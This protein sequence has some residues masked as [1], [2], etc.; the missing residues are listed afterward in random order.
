[1]N[2]PHIRQQ[3]A[4][5]F[6]FVKQGKYGDAAQ[7]ASLPHIQSIK[8]PQVQHARG[9]T[10]L[11]IG[12]EQHALDAFLLFLTMAPE[13]HPIH[14]IVADLSAK[15]GKYELANT[16]FAKATNL[17]SHV[18]QYWFNW[19]LCWSLQNQHELAKAHFLKSLAIEP[20]FAKARF[21]HAKAC[22]ALKDYVGSE[23][24]LTTLFN[25]ETQQP[26]WKWHYVYGQVL[27]GLCRTEEASKQYQAALSLSVND[28]ESDVLYECLALLHVKLCDNEQALSWLTK[29]VENHP[30]SRVLHKLLSNLKYEMNAP[31]PLRNYESVSVNNFN[32]ELQHDYVSLLMS[33]GK[34][35]AAKSALV[36]FKRN[37]PKTNAFTNLDCQIAIKEHRYDEVLSAVPTTLDMNNPGARQLCE[38][39]TLANLAL[40]DYVTAGKKIDLLLD[41]DATNQYYLALKS[42]ELKLTNKDAYEQ[43]INFHSLVSFCEISVTADYS[44]ILDFNEQLM[45]ALKSIHTM[46]KQPLGQ[47]GN[48]GTQTPG[49]LFDHPHKVIQDLKISLRNSCSEHLSNIS[50]LPY[51]EH[52]ALTRFSDQFNIVTAWSMWLRDGG[53]HVPHCHPKGWFSSAYYV[54]TPE[55][56]TQGSEQGQIYFGKPGIVTYDEI[57]EDYALTPKAGHLALFPSYYWHATKPFVSDTPRVVVAFDILPVAK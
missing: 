14:N 13:H 27:E 8:D 6:Q 24:A 16:H 32:T 51:L 49:Y 3:I 48:G 38:Y 43:L 21:E 1:M 12:Y 5:F 2:T 10:F 7:F 41:A 56:I 33:Q 40:G 47:S 31:N 42:T 9:V 20:G 4:Q 57:V 28:Q 55:C 23:Q 22:L 54:N 37:K 46:Q 30:T 26:P 25:Q 53:Y 15:Q 44:S 45:A 29:G 35:D 18:Y 17:A 19:G 11:N 50:K 36:K 52:P 39:S 34:L